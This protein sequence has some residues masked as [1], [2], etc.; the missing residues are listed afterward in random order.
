MP[1][2]TAWLTRTTGTK[3]DGPAAWP[4]NRRQLLIVAL[5]AVVFVAGFGCLF[6][7][8]GGGDFPYC[9]RRA[10]DAGSEMLHRYRV[11]AAFL[12][13]LVVSCS[14]WILAVSILR[15]SG[16][17]AVLVLSLLV[18]GVSFAAVVPVYGHRALYER[19]GLGRIFECTLGTHEIGSGYSLLDLMLKLVVTANGVVA[20]SVTGLAFAIAALL[21]DSGDSGRGRGRK[22]PVSRPAS[23]ASRARTPSMRTMNNAAED[24]RATARGKFES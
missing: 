6:L 17:R 11:A 5:P 23:E 7:F 20:V 12:L 19:I 2:A 22:D 10:R 24:G 3:A 4:L 21:A 15:R 16:S 8:H 14:A 13:L 18:G 9:P 1:R